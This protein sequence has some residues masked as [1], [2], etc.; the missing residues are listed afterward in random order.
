MAAALATIV[1]LARP[2]PVAA[3]GAG[4][5]AGRWTFTFSPPARAGGARG[6]GAA[7]GAGRAT[8]PGRAGA[9][10][11]RGRAAGAA[12]DRQ[13]FLDVKPGPAGTITGTV[14]LNPGGRGAPGNNPDRPVEISDGH[15][16]G[17]HLTFSTWSMD[18]YRNRIQFDGVVE[19]DV[20]QLTL[21]RA[22][23]TGV[24][25]THVTARRTR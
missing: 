18:G 9:S 12:S 25:T 3:Q 8:T 17:A 7:R 1:W 6:R 22:T 19:G 15:V 2:V 4:G 13:A 24:E 5:V 23:P 10:A 16:D 11:A 14:D 21:H 20:L